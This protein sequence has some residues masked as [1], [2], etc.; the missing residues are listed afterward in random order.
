MPQ[1][2]DAIA[3]KA[4]RLPAD[5]IEN[6]PG[7][8]EG[9]FLQICDRFSPHFQRVGFPVTPEIKCD[10]GDSVAGEF[11]RQRRHH[12]FAIIHPV[13]QYHHAVGRR[14]SAGGINAG[15]KVASGVSGNDNRFHVNTGG[16]VG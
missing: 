14:L 4:S 9:I 12:L 11:H 10:R 7:V 15:E 8:G 1:N 2:T 5:I 6:R 3:I 16:G 13:T